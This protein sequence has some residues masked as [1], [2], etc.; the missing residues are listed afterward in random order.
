M[1]LKSAYSA[2]MS[3]AGAASYETG[4]QETQTSAA[5]GPTGAHMF[6]ALKCCIRSETCE[7]V[8]CACAPGARC[9]DLPS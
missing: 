2:F 4:A 1:L 7:A 6:M 8:E 3:I 9:P 5:S